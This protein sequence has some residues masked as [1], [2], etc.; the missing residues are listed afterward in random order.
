M[1]RM[2]RLSG[3]LRLRATLLQLSETAEAEVHSICRREP[4]GGVCPVRVT[5]MQLPCRPRKLK[6]P[7]EPACH[8]RSVPSPEEKEATWSPALE[9]ARAETGC[10]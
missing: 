4:G 3:G 2:L 10:S 9:K 5:W 6:R 1:R 8:H 7:E